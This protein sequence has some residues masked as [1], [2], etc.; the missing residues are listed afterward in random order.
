MLRSHDL[1]H[2]EGE[3]ALLNVDDPYGA[4]PTL[5]RGQYV[6]GRI[7]DPAG[8]PDSEQLY[9]GTAWPE[10]GLTL[11]LYG[12]YRWD[13][14]YEGALAVSRDGRNFMRIHRGESLLPCGDAGEWDSGT[15]F[16]DFGVAHPVAFPDQ[17]ILRLYYAGS[18]WRHGADPYRAPSAIGA[19]DLREDGWAYL[20]PSRDATLPATVTTVPIQVD[21][22]TS[23]PSPA[24]TLRVNAQG[25]IHWEILDELDRVLPSLPNAG[26]FRVRFFLE[27]AQTRL[28]SFWFE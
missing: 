10:H 24:A 3:E 7:L 27:S 18:T 22:S 23:H 14:R 17:G 4:P 19:A 12:R 26:R 9:W 21:A 5:W 2:W 25:P 20:Q 13:A 1:I 8:E 16:M 11:C 6:A 28:Y 15:I